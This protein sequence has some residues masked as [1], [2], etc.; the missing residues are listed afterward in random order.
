LKNSA[1]LD[2]I[3]HF[4]FNSY[5]SLKDN[6]KGQNTKLAFILG[7]Y[8]LSVKFVDLLGHFTLLSMFLKM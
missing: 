1:F 2:K 5:F 4:Q 7:Y 6:S 8:Q 3:K